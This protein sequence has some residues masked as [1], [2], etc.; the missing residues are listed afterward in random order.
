MDKSF[1]QRIN[2]KDDLS[3]VVESIASAYQLGKL[4]NSKIIEIGY[5]DLNIILTTSDGNYMAKILGSFRN[6]D[7]CRRYVDIMKTVV[8]MGV[9]HPKLY[10]IN[11][12]CLFKSDQG[13]YLCVMDYIDGKSFYDFNERPTLNEAQI[14]IH[15]ASKINSLEFIPED[16]YDEWSPVNFIQE[17]GLKSKYLEDEDKQRLQRLIKPFTAIDLSALRNGLVHG[18]II[19][20]NVI[21]DTHSNKMYIIDFSCASQKPIIQELSVLLCGM[22]FNEEKPSTYS[23][24]Y[25]LVLKE[26]KPG[27]NK[28]ELDALPIFV[29]VC[30]GM[31]IMQGTYTKV[32]KHFD[33]KENDY[34]IRLGQIGLKY[35]S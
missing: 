6:E 7:N 11:G 24:Y 32:T 33:S 29:K 16:Y 22:F 28:T 31:Y 25:N 19:R 15:E 18:D 10:S 3:V 21:K 14:L 9:P 27:L 35:L 34:W 4:I 20:P 8:K 17:Y 26:Y 23:D 13:L 30:F 2:Y 5:E 1:T 12:E